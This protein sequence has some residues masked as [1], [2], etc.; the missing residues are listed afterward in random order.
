MPSEWLK[1]YSV[2]ESDI[3]LFAVTSAMPKTPKYAM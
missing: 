2:E 3:T 1:G